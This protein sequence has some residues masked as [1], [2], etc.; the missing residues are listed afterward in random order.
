MSCI[1][2]WINAENTWITLY[3]TLNISTIHKHFSIFV[4]L[5]YFF[6]YGLQTYMSLK[7]WLYFFTSRLGMSKLRC[8]SETEPKI[9]KLQ[10]VSQINNDLFWHRNEIILYFTAEFATFEVKLLMRRDERELF[11][12][13]AYYLIIFGLYYRIASCSFIIQT[14]I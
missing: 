14:L 12:F 2:I 6:Q 7:F 1:Q 3:N 11:S 4:I 9:E 13:T 8:N 10:K 5:I